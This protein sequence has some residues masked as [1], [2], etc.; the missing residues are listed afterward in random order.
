[1]SAASESESED[2]MPMQCCASCGVG[3]DDIK[4]KDCDDCDLV[5]YCSDECQKDHRPRHKEECEK[6]AAE[7]M[8]ELLFKQ[9]ESSHLGDC[10]ICCLPLLPGCVFMTCCS[11][12]V[13]VGCIYANQEREIERRL[14]QKCPFCR[15]T[16]PD[17]NEEHYERLMKRIDFCNL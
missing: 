14:E 8:N 10:P 15:K 5:R 9:P 12:H 4:L 1:M 11:K 6:R 16:A 3:S 17:T 2:I 13:C 7:L